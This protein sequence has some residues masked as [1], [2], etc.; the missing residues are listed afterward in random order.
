MWSLIV[1]QT[2]GAPGGKKTIRGQGPALPNSAG[3]GDP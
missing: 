3:A 1:T 2:M